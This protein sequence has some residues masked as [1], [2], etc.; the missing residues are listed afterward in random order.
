MRVGINIAIDS[1]LAIKLEALAK[2]WDCS[3][4]EAARRCVRTTLNL[5]E[6]RDP[7]TVKSRE[8][9]KAGLHH[10]IQDGDKGSG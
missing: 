10:E 2:E 1:D 6:A 7:K 8:Q 9:F 4:S 3:F 5:Y